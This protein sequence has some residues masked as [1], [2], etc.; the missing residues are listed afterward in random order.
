MVFGGES[1]SMGYTVGL[2]S[3]S[4]GHRDMSCWALLGR[5]LVEE[6]TSM[7]VQ[8]RPHIPHTLSYTVR[9]T[10][11]ENMMCEESVL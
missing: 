4:I 7:V 8:T 1:R 11:F 5:M 9:R 3:R 10:D 2:A 6:K